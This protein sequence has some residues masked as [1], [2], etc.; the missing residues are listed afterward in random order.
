MDIMLTRILELIGKKHGAQ[1]ELAAFLNIS[2]NNITDWK[3]GK[4]KSYRLHLPKIAEFYGVSVDW[5]S[6]NTDLKTE[7]AAPTNEDGNVF[8]I[9]ELLMLRKIHLLP[10]EIQD[11]LHA[12]VDGLLA[13]QKNKPDSQA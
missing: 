9:E 3:S 5:L 2:S 8:T 11:T 1:K 13:S 12:Q 6:G 7:K 4:N 10:K